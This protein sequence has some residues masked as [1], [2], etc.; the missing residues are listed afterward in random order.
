MVGSTDS[1]KSSILTISVYQRSEGKPWL[2]TA[3]PWKGRCGKNG[4]AWGR[5]LHPVPKNLPAKIEGDWRSPAGVFALGGVWGYEKS[6]PR[7]PGMAY[8]QI[9]SRDLWV[10]DPASEHYNRHLILDH[11][12]RTL[13]EKKAQM[14]QNDHAHSLKLF[15][16]HN[17]DPAPLSGAGSSIFFHIWRNNG[18]RATA[19]C[20]TMNEIHLRA[21]IATLD[22]GKNPVYVLLPFEDYQRL[23]PGWSLP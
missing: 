14:R 10:E 23:K 1:W 3:G 22:P 16:A 4:L 15:I 17:I 8:R 7:M 9:S 2:K 12:P 6:V 11:E 21:L 19:G 5:G 18:S 13:W 20:S